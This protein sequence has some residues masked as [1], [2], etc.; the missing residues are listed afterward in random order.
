MSRW[1]L[2]P[3]GGNRQY[4][5]QREAIRR[6]VA[7]QEMAYEEYAGNLTHELMELL[8]DTPSA[9]ERALDLVHKLAADDV[10]YDRIDFYKALRFWAVQM[11]YIDS[12]PRCR[13]HQ[14][15]LRIEPADRCR[16]CEGRGYLKAACLHDWRRSGDGVYRCTECG[17]KF[18]LKFELLMSYFDCI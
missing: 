11:G 13:G 14:E 9:H 1:W 18:P 3:R 10:L 8:K 17:A 7:A 15:L 2:Q 6:D 16:T 5:S 12:C 4:V